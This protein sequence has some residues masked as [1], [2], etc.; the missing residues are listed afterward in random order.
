MRAPRGT[1]GRER[2]GDS[3]AR[4]RPGRPAEAARFPVVSP[5]TFQQNHRGGP[6]PGGR[7]PASGRF[8][9]WLGA[10]PG[11]PWAPSVAAH[12]PPGLSSAAS[13]SVIAASAVPV[14]GD[15]VA[16]VPAEGMASVTLRW[17]APGTSALT[18]S[19][20]RLWQPG[21]RAIKNP[22]PEVDFI[23]S[24]LYL[25]DPHPETCSEPGIHHPAVTQGAGGPRDGCG[26]WE[27]D[28]HRVM[29]GAWSRGCFS[30]CIGWQWGR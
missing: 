4:L 23:P 18:G 27:G 11:R 13:A 24:D 9:P 2:P 14:R 8:L 25:A 29:A 12:L 19:C 3:P 15:S 28:D 30:R 20:S 21:M 5:L 17:T 7:L 26:A 16:L 10:R 6:G 22:L 1:E